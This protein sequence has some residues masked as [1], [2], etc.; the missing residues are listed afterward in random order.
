MNSPRNPKEQIADAVIDRFV[1]QH[2]ELRQATVVTEIPPSVR[3]AGIIIAATMTAACSAGLLW[4]VA[5]VSE[6]DKTLVRMDER[7]ANWIS[8]QDER[9]GDLEKRVEKIEAKMEKNDAAK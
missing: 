4:L 1:S 8:N 7:I 6:V 3:W 9:Y 5:T 2:P